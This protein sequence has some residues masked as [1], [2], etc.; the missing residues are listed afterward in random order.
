MDFMDVNDNHDVS[1]Y[2]FKIENESSG[3]STGSSWIR[4]QYAMF[5]LDFPDGKFII[6]QSEKSKAKHFRFVDSERRGKVLMM[7]NEYSEGCVVYKWVRLCEILGLGYSVVKRL[8]LR[9]FPR[10]G[11]RKSWLGSALIELGNRLF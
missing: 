9:D 2:D 4:R 3:E 6:P 8:H 7:V 5:A 11:N 1:T 10:H